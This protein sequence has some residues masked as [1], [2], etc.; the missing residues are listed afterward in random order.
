[1]KT[2]TFGKVLL[3]TT[4]LIVG[5]VFIVSCHLQTNTKAESLSP[6]RDTDP[7]LTRAESPTS[8]KA[9]D[10]TPNSRPIIGQTAEENF[11][12]GSYAHDRVE[13]DPGDGWVT[14][15]IKRE[16]GELI[17]I[18]EYGQTGPVGSDRLKVKVVGNAASFYYDHCMQLEDEEEPCKV[19]RIK[20]GDLDVQ[21]CE[22]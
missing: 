1:M 6:G 17:A 20:K 16:N 4:L 15:E 13:S 10:P 8:K 22:K 9:E 3:T 2:E 12:L 7:R 18:S 5:G 21:A 11:W 14:L 19:Y